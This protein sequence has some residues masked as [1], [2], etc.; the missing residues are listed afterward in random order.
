MCHSI[1]TR[2]HYNQ[3]IY[4]QNT[5][6]LASVTLPATLFPPDVRSDCK[7]QV[8]AFRSGR[9]FPLSG[10]SSR[11]RAHSRQLSVNTPVIYVGLGEDEDVFFS[12]SH[13]C[14]SMSEFVAP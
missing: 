10:N 2:F 12:L 1:Y 5:V 8:A 3:D 7:L 6:A 14:K 4:F 13:Q 11:M 9:F